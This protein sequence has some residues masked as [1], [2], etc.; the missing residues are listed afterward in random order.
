VGGLV[1]ASRG[2]KLQKYD[3][4]RG[5]KSIAVAEAAE[6]HFRR[7]KDADRLF[8]AVKLK[9]TE[10]RNFVLW[11]DGQGAN[12]AGSP[13]LTDRKGLKAGSDGL[14]DSTTIHRWRKRLA[15]EAA[16]KKSMEAAQS[17][18]VAVCEATKE[19][20]ESRLLSSVSTEW[21]TPAQYIEAARRVLGAID[22]D[23]ASCQEANATV[24]AAEFFDSVA[25]GLLLK[26]HGRVWLN[27]P[28]GG[29]QAEFT[30]KLLSEF[31]VGN[32]SAAVLLINANSTDTEWFVPLFDFPLCFTNHRIDF[33][34]GPNASENSS[35]THGS[36]FAC[37]GANESKFQNEFSA[38]GNIVHRWHE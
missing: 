27:P 23:P 37:I 35:S 14:P 8:E 3:P 16:F 13:I 5:L 17:K 12:R 4:D 21:Y 1:K 6:K 25:N 34:P 15:D 18:C 33:V 28:Y 31:S 38:F 32:V 36:V 2:G 19:T 22:L 26:W 11:W 9:L 7:A 30:G 29:L 20:L 24:N 10:Q